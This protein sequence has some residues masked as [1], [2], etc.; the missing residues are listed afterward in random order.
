[1]PGKESSRRPSRKLRV[2]R[3]P[4][5]F[6]VFGDRVRWAR[7]LRGLLARQVVSSLPISSPTYSRIENSDVTEIDP[8]VAHALAIAL[9]TPLAWLS[10]PPRAFAT[11]SGTQFRANSRMTKGAQETVSSWLTMYAE[12]LATLDRIITLPP[13]TFPFQ[14]VLE[15]APRHAAHEVR[16]ALMLKQDEPIANLVRSLEK[17]GV[18]VG[19]VDFDEEMHLRNHDASSGWFNL[20]TGRAA[21][22]IL[23]RKHSSWERTRFSTAHEA[24]HLALHRQS[25]GPDREQEAT[26]FAAEL[27]LPSATLRAEWPRHVTVMGLLELKERWGMSIAA[28]IQHGYRNE[29]LSD[30]RR[31]S[32]YKQLSNGRDPRTGERWRIREPGAG[33]RAVERPLLVANAIE[34]GFGLSPD[35]DALIR[36]LPPAR[37]G[38][39]YR[40]FLSNF[41]TNWSRDLSSRVDSS[42]VERMDNVLPMRR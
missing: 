4:D 19:V 21:P 27:L 14:T 22:V 12:L 16:S 29:L 6:S 35:L 38:E 10:A 9:S 33:A 37:S 42:A 24:G 23:S 17:L 1:M 30:E 15:A 5:K 2:R 3:V 11:S 18:F 40:E 25:S 8:S 34:V 26:E 32:L 13:T 31:V 7:Q 41:A 36:D 28:L 20:Q 39:W